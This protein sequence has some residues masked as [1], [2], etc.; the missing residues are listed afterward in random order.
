MLIYFRRFDLI[1]EKYMPASILGKIRQDNLKD[2]K[3]PWMSIINCGKRLKHW[4]AQNVFYIVNCTQHE[5]QYTPQ[6]SSF[7]D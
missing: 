5:C 3:E 2:N 4:T 7:T 1:N 6:F